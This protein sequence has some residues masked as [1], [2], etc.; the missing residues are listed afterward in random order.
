M[1]PTVSP[2]R[3][4]ADLELRKGRS[5]RG[6]KEYEYVGTRAPSWDEL[7]KLTDLFM[8]N[9]RDL[10]LNGGAITNVKGAPTAPD[11]RNYNALSLNF[12]DKQSLDDFLERPLPPAV[13]GISLRFVIC[14]DP[15]R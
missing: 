5:G 7:E 9:A 11:A 10:H 2:P 3:K 1:P 8:A 12:P 4:Y 15:L 6:Y 14:N 13:Q